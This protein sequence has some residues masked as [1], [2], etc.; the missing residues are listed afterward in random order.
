MELRRK[1]SFRTFLPPGSTCRRP[2]R[3][4]TPAQAAQ[5]SRT[6]Q[7]AQWRIIK[8][9]TPHPPR[10]A[11]ACAFSMP[12]YQRLLAAQAARGCKTPIELSNCASK[13]TS[14][15]KVAPA[16]LTRAVITCLQRNKS[17]SQAMH[18]Q[19]GTPV[20]AGNCRAQPCTP[21]QTSNLLCF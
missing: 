10:P 7:E 13:K 14:C 15:Q 16:C 4:L 12:P 3:C 6:T 17:T 21:L 18:C 2:R 20:S 5:L 9:A 19:N 11:R 8:T 1:P